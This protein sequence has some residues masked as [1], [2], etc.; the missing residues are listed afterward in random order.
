MA[1]RRTQA[2]P[3]TRAA[4]SAKG[5]AEKLEKT[6]NAMFDMPKVEMPEAFREMAEKGVEQAKEFYSKMKTAAEETAD[7]IEDSVESARKGAVDFNL[8]A[9]DAAKANTDAAF[10]FARKLAAVKTVSE[11]IELQTAFARERYDAFTAQ[12][13]EFTDHAQKLASGS[14]RPFTDAFEKAMKGFKL[15]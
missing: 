5:G 13:K 11:A 15:A 3:A 4:R 6:M 12:A 2:T 1:T 10:E 9:L 14:A 7:L 8:K